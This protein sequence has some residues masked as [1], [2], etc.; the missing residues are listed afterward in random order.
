MG[1]LWLLENDYLM[2]HQNESFFKNVYHLL[3]FGL[4]LLLFLLLLV[5]L[6]A[7]KCRI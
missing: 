6:M 3:L 5:L 7:P 4:L 1:R 2:N